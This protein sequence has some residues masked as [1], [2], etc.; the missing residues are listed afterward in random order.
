MG[1]RSAAVIGLSLGSPDIAAPRCN[2]RF[3]YSDLFT[4]HFLCYSVVP[5][6]RGLEQSRTM[7]SIREELVQIAKSGRREVCLLGQNVDAYG[8]DLQPRRTLAN[9]LKFVHDVEGIERIRFTT[10]HPRYISS[11]L[12]EACATLPKVCESFHIP[13]QSGDDD[14]LKSMGRGYTADRYRTICASIRARMPD[15]AISGDIIVGAP[16]FRAPGETEEQFQRS[17]QLVKDCELDQLNTAAYSP[18]P[19]TPAA[20]WENQISESVKVDRLA[21]LND[22]AREVALSRSQRYLGRTEEILVEAANPKN[23]K[24]VMGRTR[25][26]RKCRLDGNISELQNK[27]VQVRIIDITPYSLVGRRLTDVDPY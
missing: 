22:V 21:R 15:A 27:L 19:N 18:R 25:T 20:E 5:G 8:R 14:V 17:V 10:G 1:A 7:E 23:S 13:P 9:L 12:I 3:V 26:Q 6:T 2:L 11:R 24:E 16:G 4:V